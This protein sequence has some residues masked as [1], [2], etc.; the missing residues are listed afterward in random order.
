MYT[1][2]YELCVCWTCKCIH[3]WKYR[4]AQKTYFV[5]VWKEKK[6]SGQF[7]RLLVRKIKLWFSVK[8][9]RILC[10]SFRRWVPVPYYWSFNLK[11]LC[12]E[13]DQFV[14]HMWVALST[15]Y[16]KHK[17]LRWILRN[18]FPGAKTSLT[19][20]QCS[21]NVKYFFLWPFA[22]SWYVSLE[23]ARTEIYCF[24]SC[25]NFQLLLVI[26]NLLLYFF[27]SPHLLLCF[28]D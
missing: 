13:N 10:E 18:Y 11:F 16:F 21:W 1:N 26:Q 19:T 20:L 14:L 6:N 9:L 17:N 15:S 28:Q 5:K 24:L 12:T 27:H 22:F 3:V 4:N 25:I 2:T 23:R 8:R 7:M